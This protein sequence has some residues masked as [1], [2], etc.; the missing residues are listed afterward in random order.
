MAGGSQIHTSSSKAARPG[1][2]A[3]FWP[4]VP[5]GR[6][7]PC[8]LHGTGNSASH[9]ARTA[10]PHIRT[11]RGMRPVA[12]KTPGHWLRCSRQSY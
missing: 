9:A 2:P 12:G 5:A 3:D 4:P 6:P 11:S 1:S 10:G 8:R 7:L